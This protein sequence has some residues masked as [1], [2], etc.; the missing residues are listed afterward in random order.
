[1]DL[2]DWLC[3][4]PRFDS[5]VLPCLVSLSILHLLLYSHTLHR[6]M[7]P[8][9]LRKIVCLFC[10]QQADR[11]GTHPRSVQREEGVEPSV[12]VRLTKFQ[13]LNVSFSLAR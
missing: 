11:I 9:F 1:M 4:V 2:P 8:N 13:S 3:R 6:I 12:M 10:L 5:S 7:F